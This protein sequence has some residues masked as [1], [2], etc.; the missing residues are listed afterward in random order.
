MWTVLISL[1]DG[2][3]K[4]PSRW[5][6]GCSMITRMILSDIFKN[7]FLLTTASVSD[8]QPKIGIRRIIRQKNILSAGTLKLSNDIHIRER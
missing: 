4:E 1:L 8:N 2:N 3:L 6:Q 7:W 5:G